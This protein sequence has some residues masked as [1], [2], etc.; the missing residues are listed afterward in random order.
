[1]LC[2]TTIPSFFIAIGITPP[3]FIPLPPPLKKVNSRTYC[4]LKCAPKCRRMDSNRTGQSVLADRAQRCIGSE[5]VQDSATR[6]QGHL[7]RKNIHFLYLVY[8][9]SRAQSGPNKSPQL[10]HVPRVYSD[11]KCWKGDSDTTLINYYYYYYYYYYKACNVP[12][13][14][15]YN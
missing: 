4:G 10:D 2:Y 7:S 6:A 12:T 1:M 9:G 14:N 11:T 8:L 5:Y 3:P 15:Y 13:K